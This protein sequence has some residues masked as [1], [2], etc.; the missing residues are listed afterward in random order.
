MLLLTLSRRAATEMSRRAERIA[1]RV[2][3]S[4]AVTDALTWAGTLR[5]I[6][7]RTLREHA[8]QIELDPTFTIHDRE[9]AADLTNVVRH[10]LML[11]ETASRFPT[12]GTCLSIYSCVVSAQADLGV[13]LE[14]TFP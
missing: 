11:S 9:D 7:A 12:K 13:V 14:K 4:G 3:G 8:H 2:L 10:E 1:A 5:G 6:G